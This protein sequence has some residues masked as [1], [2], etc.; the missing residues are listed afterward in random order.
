MFCLL[1]DILL[2]CE[3]KEWRKL[4]DT[5]C[6]QI[7]SLYLHFLIPVT[8]LPLSAWLSMSCPSDNCQPGPIFTH[9]KFKERSMDDIPFSVW[10][11][12]ILSFLAPCPQ[13]SKHQHRPPHTTQPPYT[14]DLGQ[15]KQHN[16][17]NSN[18]SDQSSKMT[19]PSLQPFAA[20]LQRW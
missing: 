17:N 16:E 15:G 12:V 18:H 20:S 14:G 2:P 19:F 1:Y 3:Y 11:V 8:S 7:K 10:S 6:S 13:C 9:N 4:L 5:N